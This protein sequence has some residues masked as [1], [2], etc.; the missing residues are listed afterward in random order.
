MKSQYQSRRKARRLFRGDT[1]DVGQPLA[2][3]ATHSHAA[4]QWVY[5]RVV[6]TG[7][8]EEVRQRSGVGG[9][10]LY[11]DPGGTVHNVPSIANHTVLWV[12]GRGHESKVK[13]RF[14]LFNEAYPRLQV[15]D[16]RC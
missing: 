14:K 13:L 3:A 11:L 7:C 1:E 8:G 5:V 2:S 4:T 9:E 15:A 10:A 16:G 6:G 12:G